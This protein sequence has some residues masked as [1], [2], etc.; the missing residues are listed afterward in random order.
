MGF[1]SRSFRKV[2]LGLCKEA[3]AVVVERN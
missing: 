3:V 1:V 2:L